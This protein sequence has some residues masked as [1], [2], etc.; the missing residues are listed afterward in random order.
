MNPLTIYLGISIIFYNV[1]IAFSLHIPQFLN[2]WH[3]I[4][5]KEKINF[6]KPY[7]TNIG[8]LPLVL[9]KNR[10]T[11]KI[12]TTLNICKHMGSKLDNAK[13]THNGCLK[14][15]YHGLEMTDQDK[16]GE[17]IEHEGKIFWAYEPTRSQPFSLP[18]YHNPQFETSF[19]EIDMKCSLT[20][21]AYNT[22]DLRHPE[23]VHNAAV[24]FGNSAPPENIKYHTFHN[25]PNRVGMSFDY[26]SNEL[27]KTINQNTKTK[28][29]HMYIYP[30][31]SWSCV[32][33]DNK[34]LLIGVN[35]LPIE[36]KKTRWYVTICQNYQTSKMGKHF[37][38]MMART[39]LAQDY[40]QMQN[41]YKDNKLKEAVLFSHIFKNEEPILE[42]KRMFQDYVYPDVD[43]CVDLYN[44]YCKK[45]Q[46]QPQQQQ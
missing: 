39:I 28:N 23:Y 22:M 25:D 41:Q 46:Q 12:T 33:F 42:L 36:R 13:I 17:T 27:M 29:F 11:N 34:K 15:Q 5:I 31:F 2:H 10:R 9:W 7:V 18:F 19:L 6:S 14:C 4:G 21:S 40:Y 26:T 3:C 1:N 43:I 37:M 16:F 30:S 38:K 20:D 32:E 35:L 44:D 45:Q 8:D 24:G